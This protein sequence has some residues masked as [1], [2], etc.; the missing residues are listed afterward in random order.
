MDDEYVKILDSINELNSKLDDTKERKIDKELECENNE[1][2]NC[3]EQL[4]K[5]KSDVA[6]L[7]IQLKESYAKI[8]QTN[9]IQVVEQQNIQIG[10]H[11]KNNYDEILINYY[12][13]YIGLKNVFLNVLRL[14]CFDL[15]EICSYI[16]PFMTSSE[17][18]TNNSEAIMNV[19]INIRKIFLGEKKEAEK[20]KKVALKYAT[21]IL[22]KFLKKASNIED[23]LIGNYRTSSRQNLFMNLFDKV[24]KISYLNDKFIE[25]CVFI[26][27]VSNEIIN[28][29]S[30]GFLVGHK[31]FTDFARELLMAGYEFMSIDLTFLSINDEFFEII[32]KMKIYNKDKKKEDEKNKQLEANKKKKEIEEFRKK[33]FEKKTYKE[34]DK[35]FDYEDDK[36]SKMF[37]DTKTEPK[38]KFMKIEEYEYKKFLELFGKIIEQKIHDLEYVK[39]ELEKELKKIDKKIISNQNRLSKSKNTKSAIDLKSELENLLKQQKNLQEKLKKI[40]INIDI[41]LKNNKQFM[42]AMNSIKLEGKFE[43]K[44]QFLK[45]ERKQFQSIFENVADVVDISKEKLLEEFH[46]DE[47]YED[48]LFQ[49]IFTLYQNYLG[50]YYPSNELMEMVQDKTNNLKLISHEN[51]DG[52]LIALENKLKI[53]QSKLEK[54]L[55][56]KKTFEEL[57]KQLNETKEQEKQKELELLKRRESYDE[58]KKILQDAKELEEQEPN[59]SVYLPTK[60]EPVE[61]V[62]ETSSPN[63]NKQKSFDP[64]ELAKFAG[65]L[66][67]KNVFQPN[68]PNLSVYA[69]GGKRKYYRLIF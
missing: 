51:I 29:K 18:E 31:T 58:T 13:Y 21:N 23:K 17:Y 26:D 35:L 67:R 9:T 46:K 22:S 68:E 61:K 69:H 4:E 16:I 62:A 7:E 60:Q 6:N 14:T 2:P 56:E 19:C 44:I 48:D 41:V 34:F 38:T 30:I 54:E 43:I 33:M 8:D 20:T 28:D 45:N 10:G 39:M 11:L 52:E 32:K 53:Q 64:E 63:T 1:S 25:L 57:D 65:E 40:I 50:N 3:F 49:N 59:L 15:Y 55:E 47:K 37:D 36:L 42:D 12:D 27:N 66:E 5:I 24:A